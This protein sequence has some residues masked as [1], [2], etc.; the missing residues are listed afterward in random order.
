MAKKMTEKQAERDLRLFDK[1]LKQWGDLTRNSADHALIILMRRHRE[2]IAPLLAQRDPHWLHKAF[3]QV[4]VCHSA[5]ADMMIWHLIHAA[6]DFWPEL[7]Y[8]LSDNKDPQGKRA[9]ARDLRM[10]NEELARAQEE[11]AELRKQLGTQHKKD[12]GSA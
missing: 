9:L 7:H 3:R 4:D 1:F 12:A 6:E 11:V 10:A 5:D 8:F 2:E